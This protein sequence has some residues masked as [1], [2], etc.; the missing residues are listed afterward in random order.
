MDEKLKLCGERYLRYL[1]RSNEYHKNRY[2]TDE[3]H[4]ENAKNYYKLYYQKN[5][6]EIL[7]KLREKRQSKKL[8]C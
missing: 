3:T 1:E 2:L 6:E 7:R 5:K 4:R 8:N